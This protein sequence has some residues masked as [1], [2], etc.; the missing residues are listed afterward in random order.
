[1]RTHVKLFFHLFAQVPQ[2]YD[3]RPEGRPIRSLLFFTNPL[4]VVSRKNRDA[5]QTTLTAAKPNKDYTYTLVR[6]PCREKQSSINPTTTN[7]KRNTFRKK[8]QA[9]RIKFPTAQNNQP[10]SRRKKIPLA[11]ITTLAVLFSA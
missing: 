9:T 3:E 8:F 11:C 1:M 2:V 4:T 6:S 7:K 10:Q 5:R